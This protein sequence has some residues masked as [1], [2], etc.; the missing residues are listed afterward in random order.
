MFVVNIF[1]LIQQLFKLF[2]TM[3]NK[4]K[5]VTP[6]LFAFII[7]FS[8]FIISCDKSINLDDSITIN[9]TASNKVLLDTLT[10]SE[11]ES[12]YKNVLVK[13]P[14]LHKS[15]RQG[16]SDSKTN[17]PLEKEVDFRFAFSHKFSN[18]EGNI[19]VAPLK[20]A[21]LKGLI[22]I[23]DEGKGKK[24]LKN[25]D[26][27]YL[28]NLILYKQKDGS[29]TAYI[30]RVIPY[31]SSLKKHKNM[32]SGKEFSGEIQYFDW[33]ENFVT[34][35]VYNDGLV[36]GRITS[37]L[38][39][40][41]NKNGKVQYCQ[42][43]STTTC[44][45]YYACIKDPT[46]GQLTNCNDTQFN[47][48]YTT[49]V[50][51]ENVNDPPSGYSVPTFMISGSATNNTGSSIL[52]V[53]S[54]ARQLE[55][56][57]YSL[58]INQNDCPQNVAAWVPL[59]S[60]FPPQDVKN[61]IYSFENN[62]WSSNWGIQ[63]LAGAQG[64]VVNCDFFSVK[65]SQL[66]SNFQNNPS[67]FLNHIRLNINDFVDTNYS[68]FNPH[69]NIPGESDKWN[70]NPLGAVIYINIP[71]DNGSVVTSDYTNDHWTFTT[72]RDPYAH[73]H[74]VSGNRQFGYY[75][76]SDG[77]YTFYTRGV[78]RVQNRIEEMFGQIMNMSYSPLQFT[79]ADALWGSFV[80]KIAQYTN[81][82]SGSAQIQQ[83]VA[84]RPDWYE[85]KD[86]LTGQKPI[87][88]INCK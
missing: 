39:N 61:R 60:Y 36:V 66:P 42:W 86:V 52:D 2:T 35:H 48:C 78:D 24:D 88:S 49:S 46:T 13:T 30:M 56:N 80:G 23:N 47:G 17:H 50:I 85:V 11:A 63:Y 74:P 22:Y 83:S 37:I 26:F 15:Q 53:S 82:H 14:V 44:Y 43:V 70:N 73:N 5:S 1:L 7:F 12:W 20:Y 3:K 77:S 19:I 45:Y 18:D 65:I 6:K 28:N 68:S 54:I 62:W 81:S 64:T 34:G 21:G 38:D 8:I 59:G 67:G 41:K 40:N 10:I 27:S 55:A 16:L 4:T 32:I 69:P 75:Q 51:C 29:F 72:L 9:S 31:E 58:L 76:N 79:M 71:G 25:K 57:P 84:K 87:S 33:N